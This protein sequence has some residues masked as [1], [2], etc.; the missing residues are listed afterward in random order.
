MGTSTFN[1][2]EFAQQVLKVQI[3]PVQKIVLK[4]FYGIKLDHSRSW[5]CV[6]G[7]DK[8]P[9]QL[10]E[11]EY[12]A[13]VLVREGDRSN[14]PLSGAVD[15]YRELVLVA[16]R[17][18]GKTFLA[19]IIQAYEIYK[20]LNIPDPQSY[21]G[22]PES[23]TINVLGVS[24]DKDQAGLL[25]QETSEFLSDPMFQERLANCTQTYARFQ[26][27]REVEKYGRW[28]DDST[29]KASIKLT[30]RSCITK[31]LRGSS[32]IL[33]VLDELAHFYS[34][35]ERSA[36]AVYQAVTPSTS[37]FW[38]DF[39]PPD[40][41]PDGRIVCISSP[42]EKKGFFYKLFKDGMDSQPNTKTLVLRIPTWELNPNIPISEYEYLSAR[43]PRSF[44][45]EFG[46]EFLDE[47]SPPS[48]LLEGDLPNEVLFAVTGEDGILVQRGPGG[49]GWRVT[50]GR[51]DPC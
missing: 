23:S 32:N 51:I 13:N 28:R 7:W 36:E 34:E 2:I 18:S 47:A 30:F 22:L 45:A 5:V 35:G 42:L 37:H 39:C 20:L 27:G 10:T 49:K 48:Y 24:T 1:I 19:A 44:M 41:T 14:L 38:A 4:L 29:A 21:Y 43:D 46:A 40:K 26:T 31:G 9:I 3:T 50:T 8:P 15:T 17:R 16:G 33:V 6:N 11:I 25:Y 12:A